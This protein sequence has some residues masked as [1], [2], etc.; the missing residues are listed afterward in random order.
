MDSEDP[1]I[2]ALGFGFLS[3]GSDP[4]VCLL[5]MSTM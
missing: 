5:Y 2:W 1:G 4:F 3:F